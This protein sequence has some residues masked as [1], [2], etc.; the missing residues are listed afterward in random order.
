MVRNGVIG[1][2]QGS[3]PERDPEKRLPHPRGRQAGAQIT[4]PGNGAAIPVCASNDTPGSCGKQSFGS[5][6]YGCPK[7]K[8][9]G[10]EGEVTT[11]MGLVQFDSTHANPTR[12]GHGED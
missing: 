8:L 7:L 4:T 5:G 11:R 9:K 6:K 1:E 10:I 3:I 12:P 2:F